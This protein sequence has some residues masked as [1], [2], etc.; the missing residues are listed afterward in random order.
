MIFKKVVPTYELILLRI[1]SPK[2]N[3]I[4]NCL[5]F[6][7]F[8]KVQRSSRKLKRDQVLLKDELMYDLYNVSVKYIYYDSSG[9]F[10][11]LVADIKYLYYILVYFKSLLY[12][13]F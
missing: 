4:T 6:F 1:N 9:L 8:Q 5:F 2:Y 13:L 10:P 11:F 12:T 3:K 7:A